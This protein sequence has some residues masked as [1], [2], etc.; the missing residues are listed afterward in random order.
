MSF[1]KVSQ[2]IG[3]QVDD[4]APDLVAIHGIHGTSTNTWTRSGNENYDSSWLH[5]LAGV[6][7]PRVMFFEWSDW[8]SEGRGFCRQGIRNQAMILLDSLADSRNKAFPDG[9][10]II[11][12]GHDIG[13]VLIKEALVLAAF[14]GGRYKQIFLSVNAL[15]FFACPHSCGN[16]GRTRTAM[17]RLLA[18]QPLKINPLSVEDSTSLANGITSMVTDINHNFVDTKIYLRSTVLDIISTAGSLEKKIF[19]TSDVTFGVPFSVCQRRI[20]SHL[21]HLALTKDMDLSLVELVVSQA[22]EG[23]I[24]NFHG[25]LLSQANQ[26]HP[27]P[28]VSCKLTS[29]F[30]R[31]IIGNHTSMRDWLAQRKKDMVWIWDAKSAGQTASTMFS[32]IIETF[33][34]QNNNVYFYYEFDH[35]ESTLK[36]VES[37]LSTFL[38][39]VL[40]RWP[41]MRKQICEEPAGHFASGMHQMWHQLDLVHLLHDVLLAIDSISKMREKMINLVL[42][43][44]DHRIEGYEGL[45]QSFNNVATDIPFK[46]VIISEELPPRAIP[47]VSIGSHKS[48]MGQEFRVFD[49]ETFTTSK[50]SE[51]VDATAEAHD[52]ITNYDARPHC[53]SSDVIILIQGAPHLYD[54]AEELDYLFSQCGQDI[55][56]R[57]MLVDSFRYNKP[58]E[59]L[60]VRAEIIRLSPP[61]IERVFHH[62]LSSVSIGSETASQVILQLAVYSFRKLK[63][64]EL[65]DLINTH[66]LGQVAVDRSPSSDLSTSLNTLFGPLLKTDGINIIFGHPLLRQYLM[67]KDSTGVNNDTYQKA[68]HSIAR[69]CLAYVFSTNGRNSILKY[70]D[71]AQAYTRLRLDFASYAIRYLPSHLEACGK[72]WEET[73]QHVIAEELPLRL[74]SKAYWMQSNPIT[75]AHK[76]P[77]SSLAFFAEYGAFGMLQRTI[78]AINGTPFFIADCLLA[79]ECAARARSKNAVIVDELLKQLAGNLQSLH[80]ETLSIATLAAIDRGSTEIAKKLLKVTLSIEGPFEQ[81]DM[82]LHRATL[83][84][85][86][87]VVELLIDTSAQLSDLNIPTKNGKTLLHTSCLGG[88]LDMVKTF[89][90]M[91]CNLGDQDDAQHTALD[92]SCHYGDEVIARYLFEE[93][94]EQRKVAV[95]SGLESGNEGSQILQSSMEVAACRGYS[96][97]LESLLDKVDALPGVSIVNTTPIASISARQGRISCLARSLLSKNIDYNLLELEVSEAIKRLDVPVLISLLGIRG[98]PKKESIAKLFDKTIDTWSRETDESTAQIYQLL[99]ENARENLSDTEYINISS[100][101]F[102]DAA[103]SGILKEG[104]LSVAIKN[105][106]DIN[107][108]Q[109]SGFYS[110]QTPLYQAAYSGNKSL[111]EC[112]LANGAN[113]NIACGGRGWTVGHAAYDSVTIIQA[114]K[115]NENFDLDARDNCGATALYYAAK[116]GLVDVV[117]EILKAEVGLDFRV[118]EPDEPENI[119]AL[120][121]AFTYGRFEVAALLIEAGADCSSLRSVLGD[122]RL[123]PLHWCVR[124]NDAASLRAFLLCNVGIDVAAKD[125]DGNTALHCINWKT[126]L[127]VIRLLVNHNAPLEVT[128]DWYQT[129][130]CIAAMEN[131]LTASDFL[132]SRG[133]NINIE[134]GRRGGPLHRA[135]KFGYLSMV[136]LLCENGADVNLADPSAA[137]TPLQAACQREEDENKDAIISYLVNDRGA[138]INRPS[139]W[140]GGSFFVASGACSLDVMKLFLSNGAAVE[141][142]DKI[143]RQPIHFALHKSLEHTKLLCEEH[144]ADLTSKDVMQRTA[145]HY[146]V[147]SGKVELVQYVL[148]KHPEQLQAR[149]IDGWTPLMWS[150]RPCTEWSD[151]SEI[152]PV[153]KTLLEY[154]DSK[155]SSTQKLAIGDGLQEDIKWTALTLARYHNQGENIIELLTPTEQ[156][157]EATNEREFWRNK[158]NTEVEASAHFEGF[159][160]A[161]LMDLIGVYYSCVACSIY[162]FRLCFK[163]FRHKDKL[164]EYHDF[165]ACGMESDDSDNELDS[166]SLDKDDNQ[167]EVRGGEDI[168]ENRDSDNHSVELQ[169]GSRGGQASSEGSEFERVAN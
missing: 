130:L 17:R 73:F 98:F 59:R 99:Y 111:V 149:D 112:F 52:S 1:L 92:L 123:R 34:H 142:R 62:A 88:H 10:P 158:N 152:F 169:E 139:N 148:D 127:S 3:C 134:A 26:Q 19:E 154:S 109:T 144:G 118:S 102:W 13:G 157:I 120:F 141:A 51:S 11:F 37:M 103:R 90:H 30:M 147:V 36:T 97:V 65:D 163:C 82:L 55:D 161:C 113:P 129:P 146:A 105:G 46:V 75:R 4:A 80:K 25:A 95:L 29:D 32:S 160:D 81:Q 79:L 45:L 84:G 138:D 66:L 122:D 166:G 5:T 164:H 47:S 20:E 153:I 63:L 136:K 54:Y 165:T 67:D 100:R 16:V 135:C 124:R 104:V 8:L 61:T 38:A 49:L 89:V 114:L 119:T 150:V 168:E 18:L 2:A 56:L 74:C 60:D 44:L 48:R 39:G 108:K 21:S 91:K 71:S 87:D 40:N 96:H 33:P 140:W 42:V 70:M 41:I 132:I 57:R 125:S 14:L 155:Y 27:I 9:R 145:L 101:G 167:D 121:R 78:A 93:A 23:R 131:N 159:C 12:V 162:D 68:H 76:E 151:T 128:N 64:A 115:K 43:N 85:H 116:W 126:S 7:N 106:A 50:A 15:I 6:P 133:A 53:L 28:H 143:S 77:A 72:G 107:A 137:G 86:V 94:I 22:F 69:I 83:L 110:D 24:A 156:D 35:F 58:H 117:K 31:Q